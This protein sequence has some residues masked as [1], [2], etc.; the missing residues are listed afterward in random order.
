MAMRLTTV[1]AKLISNDQCGFI[2]GRNIATIP[3]ITD[4][5][6]KHLNNENLP[7]IVVGIDF[8]KVFDTIS[9]TLIRNSFKIYGYNIQKTLLTTTDGSPSH[10]R[11]SVASPKD[12]PYPPLLFVL[13]VILLANKIRANDIKGILIKNNP[14]RGYLREIVTKQ[15]AGDTTLYL[16]DKEFLDI[17]MTIFQRFSNISGLKM[18]KIK[19]EQCGLAAIK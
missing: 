2:R 4:D 6:I 8:A 13:E 5:I 15:F 7:G 17:A 9:K 11:L 18:N 14:V 19:Q 10:L 12:A 1:I 16:R 3:K